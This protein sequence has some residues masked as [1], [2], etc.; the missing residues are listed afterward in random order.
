MGVTVK[1]A[2]AL[3]DDAA[4]RGSCG[5]LNRWRQHLA[6]KAGFTVATTDGAN[7]SLLEGS[8]LHLDWGNIE[9]TI[10]RDL[11]GR[12]P[13]VPY[14]PDGSIEP[15]IILLAHPDDEGVIQKDMLLP[16]AERLEKLLPL[17]DG[18][19]GGGHIGSYVEK[20]QT[21]IDGCRAA[22]AAGESLDF[23]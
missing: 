17:L 8:N 7:A 19:D 3:W 2:S 16:L 5:A 22:H 4:W 6:D 13:C 12:W 1:H 23:L 9:K 15:L 21:F 10:G 18:E 20:T 11:M 14:R